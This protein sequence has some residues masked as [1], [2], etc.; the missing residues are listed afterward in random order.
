MIDYCPMCGADDIY[1]EAYMSGDTICTKCGH[2]YNEDE[3][4][5]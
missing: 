3:E 5:E 4:E 2:V 1:L